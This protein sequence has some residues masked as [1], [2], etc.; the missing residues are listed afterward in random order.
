M[1]QACSVTLSHMTRGG[2]VTSALAGLL[3]AAPPPP[4]PEGGPNTASRPVV[5]GMTV[6]CQSWGREWASDRMV[7]AMREL[8]ELGVNWIAI[9]PYAGIAA[10][11]TVTVS[12]RRYEDAGWI[13]R[14]V[15]EAHRL[16]LQIMV[17]P[18]LAYW[19][20]P[21]RW[22]GDIEFAAPEQW[23]R[24]FETYQAW[25]TLVAGHSAAADAFS[26]GTELDRTVLHEDRWRRVIAAARERLGR[27]VHLTYS[28]NWSDYQSVP[29]WDALDVIGVQAYFPVAE[30]AGP[31]DPEALRRAWDGHLE[32]LGTLSRRLGK[33]VVFTELGYARSPRA[34]IE[35][36]V[37]R[38]GGDGAEETQRRCME[39][40]LRALE[41]NDIV[42][43]A[44]LWKWFPGRPHPH[45]NYLM[46]EPAMRR[47]IADHWRAGPTDL[48]RP[49]A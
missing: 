23:D 25:I 37:G 22:R 27:G 10:D 34:G 24:F 7:E 1:A 12:E 36:W 26:V 45:E 32:R 42:V 35:P 44:F 8:R 14:P 2:A 30:V 48:R 38:E 6:S 15:E 3:A 39:A 29:F 33:K 13:T 28:S 11:G 31:P 43:G 47:V 9:H 21:F 20:S 49:S 5:R 16:G 46:S 19:G 41:G 40:S 17:T 18:H 4:P